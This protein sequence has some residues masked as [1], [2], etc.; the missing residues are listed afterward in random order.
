ME[1]R[2]YRCK[3][4]PDEITEYREYA[5]DEGTSPALFVIQNEGTYNAASHQFC[6][7]ECY[8]QIG[9]PSSTE[10]WTAP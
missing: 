10:G 7:T 9:M 6:C 3:R 4:H 1:V 2:C 8:I 5:Q